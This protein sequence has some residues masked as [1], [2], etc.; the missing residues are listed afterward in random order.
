M[1]CDINREG[2]LA[3]SHKMSSVA[4]GVLSWVTSCAGEL[5][6]AATYDDMCCDAMRHRLPAQDRPYDALRCLL[7]S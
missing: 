7:S 4:L 5:H 6:C 1:R 2:S 3:V